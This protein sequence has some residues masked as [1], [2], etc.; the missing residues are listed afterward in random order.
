[1]GEPLVLHAAVDG[2]GRLVALEQTNTRTRIKTET[3]KSVHSVQRMKTSL[4]KARRRNTDLTGERGQVLGGQIA[5]LAANLGFFS[6]V[7]SSQRRLRFQKVL[8]SLISVPRVM[9]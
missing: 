7:W 3:S 9:Y 1:M 4:V 2:D 6:S 5:S 8:L